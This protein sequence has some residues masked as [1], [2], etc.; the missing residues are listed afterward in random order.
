MLTDRRTK[1]SVV[2]Y[3]FSACVLRKEDISS[4]DCCLLGCDVI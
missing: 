2:L 4:E 3:A 1:T